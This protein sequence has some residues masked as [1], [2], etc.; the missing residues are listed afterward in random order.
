MVIRNAEGMVNCRIV[1][2]HLDHVC[3]VVVMATDHAHHVVCEE[4][5]GERVRG[6]GWEEGR[7]IHFHCLLTEYV[8]SYSRRGH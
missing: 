2:F 3:V 5:M 7:L 1:E 8:P 4:V 6:G